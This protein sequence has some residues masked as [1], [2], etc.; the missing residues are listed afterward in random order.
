LLANPIP[1]EKELFSGQIPKLQI[2][3]SDA[4]YEN[5]VKDLRSYVKATVSEGT[6]VYTDVGIHAKGG[7][8]SFR[9][10]DR[11]PSLTLNF[12]KFHKGQHFHGMDKIHLNNS[13]QDL[14]YMTE[15]ICRQLFR[16]ADL[17]A[18]RVGNARVEFN[19]RDLGLLRPGGRRR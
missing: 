17:P 9:P 2:Q 11:N 16:S 13:V 6:N 5:L 3:I 1:L 19:G 14:T 12:D 4:E 15:N 7:Q 8:G 18:T 10:L